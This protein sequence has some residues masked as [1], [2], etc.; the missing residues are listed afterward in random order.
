MEMLIADTA[1][2]EFY[3]YMSAHTCTLDTRYSFLA[4]NW[5]SKREAKPHTQTTPPPP[6]WKKVRGGLRVYKLSLLFK[7]FSAV[8]Y[9][10]L[11]LTA[12]AGTTGEY[13]VFTG[14]S[15]GGNLVLTASMKLKDFGLRLPDRVV[16]CY[17][18]TLLQ[19]EVSPSRFL[20]LTDSILPV[21]IQF[22][23]LQ[24]CVCACMHT[25]VFA[26]MCECACDGVH[27]YMYIFQKSE[28]MTALML[29]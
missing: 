24:V 29:T 18:V 19:T 13:I 6:P 9:A 15:A 21:G 25:C 20:S 8:G 14:D 3:M 10:A 22:A 2:Q 12:T 5:A 16:S 23:C 7:E 17:P 11:L 4:L 28:L 1:F 26:C 27:A